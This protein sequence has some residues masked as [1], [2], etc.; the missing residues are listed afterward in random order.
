MSKLF[1]YVLRVDDG[2]APNPYH[3]ACT[4]TICKPAIRRKAEIGDWV[5]GFGSKN[6]RCNDGKTH[7]LSGHVVYAMKIT[8]KVSMCLY[9]GICANTYPGKIPNWEGADFRAWVG[10]CIYDYSQGNDPQMRKGVHDESNRKTDLS[11]LFALISTQFYYFGDKPEKLS[12]ELEGIVMRGRG[13]RK[14]VN[15]ELVQKFES[16]IS[17]FKMNHIYSDPQMKFIF[18]RDDKFTCI[19]ECSKIR[20]KITLDE[21]EE[22][23]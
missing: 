6:A 18:Y 19:G 13:H 5:I 10:D 9:D 22:I 2:A 14:I 8:H 21:P 12:D 1:T 7:D 4:L 16:W 17:Q 3:G 11:G 20:E 15:P 23:C